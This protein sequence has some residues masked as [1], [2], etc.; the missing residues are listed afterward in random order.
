MGLPH[1]PAGKESACS[2]ED[3]GSM[4]GWGISLGEGNGSPFQRFCLK[5]SMDKGCCRVMLLGATKSQ[6]QLC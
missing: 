2:A 3:L 1:C 4:P 6:I 5:N